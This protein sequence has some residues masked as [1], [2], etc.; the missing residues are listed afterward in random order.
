MSSKNFSRVPVMSE[1]EDE[2]VLV[3][4][5]VES[6][7]SSDDEVETEEVVVETVVEPPPTRSVSKSRT[8]KDQ[9][10]LSTNDRRLIQKQVTVLTKSYMSDMHRRFDELVS[11]INSGILNINKAVVKPKTSKK[12][13]AVVHRLDNIHRKFIDKYLSS[14]EK[15]EISGKDLISTLQ[16]YA[17]TNDV[18]TRSASNYEALNFSST[19]VKILSKLSDNTHPLNIFKSDSKTL[20]TKLVKPLTVFSY[21][22]VDYS[23]DESLWDNLI[24]NKKIS[25][26]SQFD[27]RSLNICPTA[28]GTRLKECF[29]KSPSFSGKLVTEESFNNYI[30]QVTMRSTDL[31]FPVALANKKILK[32]LQVPY[33]NVESILYTKH[34][35]LT[36]AFNSK[37]N[38]DTKRF[39]EQTERELSDVFVTIELSKIKVD[40]LVNRCSYSVE[41]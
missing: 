9:S 19:E 21:D 18:V 22:N 17:F 32:Y 24:K 26:G 20:V 15:T 10:K 2:E 39:D 28:L 8:S 13:P 41:E 34:S 40:E 12:L 23:I 1:D 37:I 16:I 36:A 4:S 38:P 35:L 3:S 29:K 33:V 30:A 6:S 14:Y 25:N 11:D 5:R 31:Y 27:D 7:D